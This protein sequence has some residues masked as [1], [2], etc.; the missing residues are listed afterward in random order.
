MIPIKLNGTPLPGLWTRSVWN[1]FKLIQAGMPTHL[2]FGLMSISSA[3]FSVLKSSILFTF[4]VING[5]EYFFRSIMIMNKISLLGMYKLMVWKF[6]F[7]VSCLQ[8][9]G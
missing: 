5:S 2:V 6:V 9:P 4:G 3:F 1:L 8:F 7:K